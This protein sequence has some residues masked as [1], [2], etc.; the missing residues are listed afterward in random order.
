MFPLR[1]GNETSVTTVDIAERAA[2]E[3]LATMG[4]LGA[5]KAQTT[6]TVPMHWC[7]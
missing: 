7:R 2:R 5:D 4:D 3:P 6:V 1:F